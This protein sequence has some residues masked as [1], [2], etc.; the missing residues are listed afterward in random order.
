[1]QG[2]KKGTNMKTEGWMEID[3]EDGDR[4]SQM[5]RFR[6]VRMDVISP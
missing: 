2:W 1:M 6:K 4:Q 5:K 3:E